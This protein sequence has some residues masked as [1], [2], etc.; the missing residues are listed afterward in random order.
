MWTWHGGPQQQALPAAVLYFLLGLLAVSPSCS[1]AAELFALDGVPYQAG[2][3]GSPGS[4]SLVTIDL[5]HGTRTNVSGAEVK[6]TPGQSTIDHTNSV[7]YFIAQPKA[8]L[9]QAWNLTVVGVSLKSGAVVSSTAA[10]PGADTVRASGEIWTAGIA[11]ASDLGVLV[12][13]IS[14]AANSHVVGTMHPATGKWTVVATVDKPTRFPI[15]NVQP[16]SMV[17]VPGQQS[18]IFQ[19]GVNHVITQ[20][21]YDFKT[22]TLRNATSPQFTS[23][24]IAVPARP[25]FGVMHRVLI[26]ARAL[27]MLP[28]VL[29]F[30]YNP[31]DGMVWGHGV[32][33][34]PNGVYFVRTLRKMD[35]STLKVELVPSGL[36]VM[37]VDNGGATLDPVQILLLHTV[38]LCQSNFACFNAHLPVCDLTYS[39]HCPLC[40]RSRSC[41]GQPTCSRI[42]H[43][44]RGAARSRYTSR[45][46]RSLTPRSCPRPSSSAPRGSAPSVTTTRRA[47]RLSILPKQISR[48]IYER[49]LNS[50]YNHTIHQVS[51]QTKVTVPRASF[52]RVES[53]V[54]KGL[55]PARFPGCNAGCTPMLRVATVN[56]RQ[57]RNS[58]HTWASR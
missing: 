39:L 34:G 30:V 43:R 56:R 35:P 53:Q 52:P 15:G 14:T 1:R 54:R 20:F 23:M 40:R 6:F 7:L 50:V 11:Y 5:E 4:F 28:V 27:V 51:K 24:F 32:T 49:V 25:W 44:P 58:P 45:R 29:D 10:I 18:Y 8:D 41:T 17:Y 47:L 9:N 13:S 38:T 46:S 2:P 26:I 48:K 21:A 42:W 12:L 31:K 22:G 57:R 16:C 55:S 33:P 37:T 36:K 3:Q 19:L